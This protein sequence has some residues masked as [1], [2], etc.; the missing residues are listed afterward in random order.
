[1]T[2]SKWVPE[3]RFGTWFQ[4]TNMWADYVLIEAL[5]TLTDLLPAEKLINP[6]VL[7]AG[8]GVGS[9][10]GPLHEIFGAIR[11][12][13]V[14]IDSAL[15]SNAKIQAEQAGGNI[16]VHTC[17]VE[18]LQLM[19]DSVD[20]ILCHQCLH[21]VGDQEQALREFWRV[22]RPNGLLLFSESCRSFTES[23][24]VKLFFRHPKGNQRTE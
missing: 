20:I 18:Q 10:F 4:G 15:T 21:H 11:L 17:N 9:A 6:I 2:T 23:L 1:M 16:E 8:C 22:L 24:L 12:I 7:D 3:T 5:Q 13:A 14:D 19:D